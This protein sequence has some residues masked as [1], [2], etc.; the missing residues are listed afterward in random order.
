MPDA[1][2]RPGI[3]SPMLPKI[4]KMTKSSTKFSGGSIIWAD[5]TND[6]AYI[7]MRNNWGSNQA[8]MIKTSQ[9]IISATVK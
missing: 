2:Y 7:I 5:P 1:A 8:P 3:P 6:T 4:D 9:K